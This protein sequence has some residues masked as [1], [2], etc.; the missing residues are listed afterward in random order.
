[1]VYRN[2]SQY[3]IRKG[4]KAKN[5]GVEASYEFTTG[6]EIGREEKSARKEQNPDSH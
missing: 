5:S 1:M 6:N 4:N 2:L 3:R